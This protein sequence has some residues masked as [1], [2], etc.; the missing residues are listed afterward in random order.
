VNL[1]DVILLNGASSA[2]KSSLVLAL[3][4]RLPEAYVRFGIDDFVF[5]RSPSRWFGAAEGIRFEPR[6][7]RLVDVIYGE[8]VMRL[9]RAF[10]RSVRACIDEGLKVV[11]DEVILRRDLLDDWIA[12]LAG[13]D[14]FFVGVHCD[15]QELQLR[16]NARRDRTRGTSLA[17]IDVVH[18]HGD[19]DLVLDSTATGASGLARQVFAALETRSGESAF[20]RLAR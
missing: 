7:D 9:Q 6:P 2:G 12:A 15:P 18:A 4:D 17:Q 8:A 14:V 3:Q 19:Y 13:T 11:I 16:E 10:H 5:D 1:P 20:S